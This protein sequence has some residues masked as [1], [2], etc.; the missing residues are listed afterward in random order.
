MICNISGT[1]GRIYMRVFSACSSSR[2]LSLT[3]RLNI[4][5]LTPPLPGLNSCSK[6]GGNSVEVSR[7]IADGFNKFLYTLCKQLT[8]FGI[9][10]HYFFARL[11]A[12]ANSKPGYCPLFGQSW[13]SI[14]ILTPNALTM[15]FQTVMIFFKFLFLPAHTITSI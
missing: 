2:A 13:S 7:E 15:K 1:K 3:S 4:L 5:C 14:I 9:F 12:L 8:S 10:F 11:Y 6:I